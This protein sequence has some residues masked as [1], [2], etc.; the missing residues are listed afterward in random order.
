MFTEVLKG[1][2]VVAVIKE[3]VAEDGSSVKLELRALDKKAWAK[4]MTKLL[5][6]NI[7]EE[8][9]GLAINKSYWADEES[10]KI[11]YCW[12]VI[13]WG[14]L[15]QAVR[16]LTPFLAELAQKQTKPAP[17]SEMTMVT[18]EDQRRGHTIVDRRPL[19]GG[20]GSVKGYA[21]VIRLPHRSP[22]TGHNGTTKKPS[23]IGK[24]GKWG[25]AQ[26]VGDEGGDPWY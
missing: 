8:E 20:D 6:D 5:I 18:T 9:F 3:V 24:R 19:R 1:S 25:F 2:N 4:M 10:Q 23:D 16:D 7:G 13:I 11:L 14:D 26:A 22:R 12:V 17:P 21:T 15:E